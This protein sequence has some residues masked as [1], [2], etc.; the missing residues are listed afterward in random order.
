MSFRLHGRRVGSRP[1]GG[2]VHRGHGQLAGPQGGWPHRDHHDRGRRRQP[3]RRS[4]RRRGRHL[5]RPRGR[6]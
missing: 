4:R 1:D 3:G 2:C 5:G 6:P